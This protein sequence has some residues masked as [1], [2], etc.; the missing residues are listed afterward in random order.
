MTGAQS[1]RRLAVPLVVDGVDLDVAAM[2][3]PGTGTPIVFL[4]GFGSTKEDYADVLRHPVLGRRPVLAYD[5]PGCGATGCSDLSAITVPFLVSVARAML[6]HA[7]YRRCH[8]V[9]HSMG[10]LTGLV[11]A[12]EE[13]SR[14]AAFV[15]IEGNLA[16]EDCFFSRQV[17]DHPHPDPED[18][19]SAFVDRVAGAPY[20]SA[21]LYASRLRHT[22]RA[23]AV[24]PILRSMVDISDHGPLLEWFLG[25]P[26]PRMLMYGEQN[27]RLSYLPRLRDGGVT[28]AEI[29]ECGHFPMYANAVQ[30][31]RHLHGFL[32]RVEAARR[33]QQI[34]SAISCTS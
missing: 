4:H 10:G 16:P 15:S 6:A 14:V 18:F 34:G 26:S 3:K 33:P 19:L 7:G 17:V 32:D 28:L 5:A 23:G 11:L 20:Y 1:W 9:G 31:W 30:M 13:P 8:L 12:H 21:S 22:V 25:L 29:P 27:N 24:A 2:V